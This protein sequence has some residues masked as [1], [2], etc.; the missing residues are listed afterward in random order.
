MS[1]QE[2]KRVK[3]E[4]VL[5]FNPQPITFERLP[6]TCKKSVRT[7]INSIYVGSIVRIYDPRFGGERQLATAHWCTLKG[8]FVT[9]HSEQRCDFVDL[10]YKKWIVDHRCVK[11][12]MLKRFSK[13][14]SNDIDEDLRNKTINE[15]KQR[16]YQILM[17][18]TYIDF[19]SRK[20]RESY[21]CTLFKMTCNCGCSK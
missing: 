8:L 9:L 17:N 19:P 14:S 11:V 7:H 6:D 10:K 12:G 3:V 1:N 13:A 5:S 4:E 20:D 18:Y 21:D 2:S 15:I 16:N